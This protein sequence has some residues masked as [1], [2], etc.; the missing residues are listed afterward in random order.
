VS[1]ITPIGFYD[2]LIDVQVDVQHLDDY[3]ALYDYDLMANLG[4]I[5]SIDANIITTMSM[6][7]NTLVGSINVYDIN[8]ELITGIH[9]WYQLDEL[10]AG[11]Y[12]IVAKLSVMGDP[13]YAYADYL[14]ILNVK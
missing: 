14:F 1:S 13:S 6:A 2:V 11:T 8:H 9:D 7:K 10:D 5:P 3:M 4:Q 12:F